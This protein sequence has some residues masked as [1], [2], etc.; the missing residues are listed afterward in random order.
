MASLNKEN[1]KMDGKRGAIN[2]SSFH[3]IY[4][5]NYAISDSNFC[6]YDPLD[7]NPLNLAR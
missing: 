7:A 1:L 2:C 6:E 4:L 5:F 3:L